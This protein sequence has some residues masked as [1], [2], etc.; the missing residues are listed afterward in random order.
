[1]VDKEKS[2]ESFRE[3]A[4]V[5]PSCVGNACGAVAIR[6]TYNG[7]GTMPSATIHNSSSAS[8]TVILQWTS[9]VLAQVTTT[10]IV[11]PN[12]TRTLD[13]PQVPY[14]KWVGAIRADKS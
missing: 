13:N 12:E 7:D 5:A 10:E 3:E 1:M 2:N 8:V 4:Y 11:F 6:G 9:I 14:G